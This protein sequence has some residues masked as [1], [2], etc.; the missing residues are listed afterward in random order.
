MFTGIVE[1]VG[2]V[3]ALRERTGGSVLEVESEIGDFAVGGSVAVNGCCLTAIEVTPGAFSCDLSPETLRVTALSDLKAG[4]GVN[5]E[6]SMKAGGS[7]DGHIVSGHVD[8]V[9]TIEAL[10]R[11]GNSAELAVSLPSGLVR[12]VAPKG[13]IAVDGISLTVVDVDRARFTVAL[14]PYTLEH[15]NLGA[16]RPGGRVNLEVDILAKYVESLLRP[17]L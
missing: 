1:K 7:F 6:R 3:R 15:T 9:G 17:R 4:S 12:Y 2:R 14:I 13:S 10:K 8:G 11:S 5:L 16:A